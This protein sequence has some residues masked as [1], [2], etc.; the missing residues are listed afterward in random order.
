MDSGVAGDGGRGGNGGRGGTGGSSGAYSGDASV[1][2]GNASDGSVDPLAPTVTFVAPMPARDPNSDDVVTQRAIAVRCKIV[3]STAAG[4]AAVDKAAVKIQVQK[5]DDST[6]FIDGIV[7][8]VAEDEYEATFDLSAHKN[9]EVQF[10]CNGRDLAAHAASATFTT[11]LD[12]GPSIE[13]ITPIDKERVSLKKPMAIEFRVSPAPLKDADDEADVALVTLTVGGANTTVTE[14]STDPGLYQAIVDFSDKT[15]FPV[16]PEAAQLQIFATNL[17]TPVA[18]TR[19][20]RAD[21]IID[22]SGPNVV[23]M[24]PANGSIQHGNVQLVVMVTDP[25]GIEADSLLASINTKAY[26]NWVGTGPTFTQTFDTRDIDKKNEQTQLTINLTA[27]DIVG[28]KTDPPVTHI[29]RLDNLPPVISLDPPMIRESRK[30]GVNQYC[31]QAF[32]PLGPWAVNDLQTVNAN[33]TPR[34]LVEDQTNTAPGVKFNYL[35]GTNN[36]SVAVYIQS[37]IELPLL[38]DTDNDGTCDAINKSDDVSIPAEERITA[39]QDPVKIQLNAVNPGGSAWFAKPTTPST[40]NDVL[41][42][43]DP[44]GSDTPPETVCIATDMWR[45]VPA[46]IQGK[47]PAVFAF[48]PSNSASSGACNGSDWQLRDNTRGREGWVCVAARVE[49]NIKNVGVSQPLRLCYDDDPDTGS[50]N[51]PL[52]PPSCTD[53]CTISNAQKFADAVWPMP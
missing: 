12:L 42:P 3:A 6:A 26:T 48:T 45:A 28:N 16:Q 37:L 18:P 50:P 20:M 11:L 39:D 53:G 9:G 7:S 43:S 27:V 49:D 13:L 29:I 36:S 10:K 23:V 34:A 40:V 52:P 5:A 32:D 22:S 30:S 31:S 33:F 8:S 1:D 19:N 47:P 38:V 4:A 2:G 24:S 25:S 21:V 35:S 51:C 44:G 46:R 17:R 15:K 14:S 41:C